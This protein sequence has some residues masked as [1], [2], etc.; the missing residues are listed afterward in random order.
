MMDEFDQR[1]A[2]QT[3]GALKRLTDAYVGFMS[4]LMEDMKKK[5]QSQ[6]S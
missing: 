1:S 5:E 4:T 3:D 6:E 2:Q